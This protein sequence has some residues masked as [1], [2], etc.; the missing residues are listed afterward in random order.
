MLMYSPSALIAS[1]YVNEGLMKGVV[2][3][4]SHVHHTLVSKDS[5][6]IYLQMH[7][8]N[9]MSGQVLEEWQSGILGLGTQNHTFAT[10]VVPGKS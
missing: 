7:N 6:C 4:S 10:Y 5:V 3:L 1:E 8:V 2:F 9:E